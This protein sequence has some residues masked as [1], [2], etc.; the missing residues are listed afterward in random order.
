MTDFSSPRSRLSRPLTTRGDADRTR[1][2]LAREVE[3]GVPVRGHPVPDPGLPDANPR[4]TDVEP[5]ARRRAKRQV[6]GMFAVSAVLVIAAVVFYFGFRVEA[7]G[8]DVDVG[9]LQISNLVLGLTLGLFLLLAGVGVVHWSRVLMTGTEIVE[10]RD[11]DDV[12]DSMQQDSGEGATGSGFGRRR[13]IR[14][15]LLGA[16]ALL[17]V[18]TVVALRGLERVPGHK[19]ER[20]A[21]AEGV[22]LLT[23]ISYLP[24]R[25]SDLQIGGMVS[26]LPASFL[27]L[28]E[29]GSARLN[30]RAK[31]PVVLVRMR[32][33]ELAPAE[34]RE[35]WHVDGIIAYSKICTHV[36]CPVSLYERTTHHLLCP[37]HQ[38]TFDLADNGAVVFGPATRSLP[39]LPLAV[40]DDG[41][42]VAQSDFTEA[43]GPSYWEREA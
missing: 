17:P 6:A 24:I 38:A 8:D 27:D 19:R 23:D 33:E 34:G 40:D 4:L 1:P 10:H 18:P 15:S 32:P 42:L 9:D 25:A 30:E 13:L 11:A 35:N 28:P 21:W 43:V 22:R 37:C 3:R 31:S 39:Q 14:N 2:E 29:E 12:G 16:V 7:R 41:F 26:V 36:G 5:R 20:T